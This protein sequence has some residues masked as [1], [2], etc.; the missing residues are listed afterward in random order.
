MI[1]EMFE[2]LFEW[3]FTFC[4]IIMIIG[5]ALNVLNA[6]CYILQYGIEL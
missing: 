6:I 4:A 2:K 3:T 5:F 1:A